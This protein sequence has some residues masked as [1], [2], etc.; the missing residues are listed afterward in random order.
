MVPLLILGG[1]VAAVAVASFNATKLTVPSVRRAVAEAE[2]EIRDWMTTLFA[3]TS[4][5][6]GNYWSVQRN[7]DGQGVSYGFI[8]WTQRRGGLYKVLSRMK[9]KDGAAFEQIF[10]PSADSML[11]ATQRLDMGPVD[12]ALLWNEPWLSRFIEAGHYPPFQEAQREEAADSEYL[13]AARAIANLLGVK[14]ERAMVLYYNRTVHQG[15]GG[16]TGPAEVLAAWYAQ[17][18]SRRP[19]NPNDVLAQYAWRCAAKFRRIGRPASLAYNDSGLVWTP[20]TTEQSELRTGDYHSAKVA[21]PAG[22]YHVFAG[23]LGSLYDLITRRSSEILLDPTLRD[24]PVALDVSEVPAT[25]GG[26]R[27]RRRNV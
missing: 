25:V 5:H 24:Q 2:D 27:P 9:R 16:A 8:Q 22:A 12:G 23:K 4:A 15:A 11:A 6:E 10:G 18:P 1:V 21:A 7:L 14:T 3:K 19:A 13:R 26:V 20:V 17:D